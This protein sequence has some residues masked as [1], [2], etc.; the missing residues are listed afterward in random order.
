MK[1]LII[2]T[3]VVFACSGAVSSLSD[4]IASQLSVGKVADL[5]HHIT[6]RQTTPQDIADCTAAIVDYQCGSSGYAQQIV[7]IALECRNETY[8]R[9]AANTCARSENGAFCGSATTR[10]TLDQT[11]AAST[12][13]GAVSSG[14]CPSSC[15][16]FL[17]SASS[18]LGCCI[19]TYINT[20]VSPL[21]GLYGV[22]VDYHLWNLCNVP[23]PAADCGNG[24]P[25]NP[26][27]DAQDCTLQEFATRSV[28]YE[29]MAS[30][31]QPLVDT[32]LRNGRC[33]TYVR[34]LV[35]ICSRNENNQFCG[36]VI[37]SS[38]ISSG[39]SNDPLFISLVANCAASSS[40]FC[41]SSCR[42]AATNIKNSYGCC[43]NVFNISVGGIQV[44]EQNQVQTYSSDHRTVVAVHSVVRSVAQWSCN[45]HLLGR[46][47]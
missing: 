36:A 2:A 31:G 44:A 42:S 12:C 29:C 41:S 32:L 9:N 13:S 11:Q 33:D 10:F 21:L 30:V 28:N 38:A 24:L 16:S 37:G 17:Q 20:T 40:S 18:T 25:L 7:N 46:Y 8:A 34:G 3:V 35:G 22:Y 4:A 15:R 19:N 6:K 27:Q 43:V 47:W 5:T 39:G 14:S 26:P 1:N 23:L 45:Q